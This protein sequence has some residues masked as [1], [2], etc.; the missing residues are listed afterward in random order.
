M[1]SND[2]SNTLH[3]STYSSIYT[4]PTIGYHLSPRYDRC[5][6]SLI[7]RQAV[8]DALAY[9]PFSPLHTQKE[10]LYFFKFYE[11]G[12]KVALAYRPD[13][14]A[15]THRRG[16]EDWLTG[17]EPQE[18]SQAYMAGYKKAQRDDDDYQRGQEEIYWGDRDHGCWKAD[19][20][21]YVY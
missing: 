17:L 19:S 9:R 8:A 11:L 1:S 15:R 13:D 7:V 4:D 10:N 18:T 2:K 21:N 14:Y 6:G 3:L 20:L 5:P 12:Y 16:Y